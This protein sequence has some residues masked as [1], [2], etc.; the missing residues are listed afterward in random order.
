MRK[1]RPK[2]DRTEPQEPVWSHKSHFGQY[3]SQIEE[4][5][6]Q[7]LDM[8]KGGGGIDRAHGKWAA[9]RGGQIINTKLNKN[10]YIFPVCS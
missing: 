10:D 4:G 8:G 9:G 2:E 5:R 6:E 3:P 1:D 7:D